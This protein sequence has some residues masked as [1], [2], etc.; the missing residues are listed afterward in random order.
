MRLG[1][2][3]EKELSWHSQSRLDFSALGERHDMP[4][5]GFAPT[6]GVQK[7]QT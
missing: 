2:D 4:E 6:I 3:M 5:A 7:P 1:V